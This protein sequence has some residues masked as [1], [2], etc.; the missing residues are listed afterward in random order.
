MGEVRE[1]RVD[2]TALDMV[3]TEAREEREEI[4]D[5]ATDTMLDTVTTTE[6]REARVVIIL[7]AMALVTMA[8]ARE[9]KEET[10]STDTDLATEICLKTHKGW[11]ATVSTRWYS[12]I[13]ARRI[14]FV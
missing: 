6:A 8:R 14:M 7:L 2:T 10:T 9:E 13:S 12:I 11:A 5:P 4:T 3:T 1:E